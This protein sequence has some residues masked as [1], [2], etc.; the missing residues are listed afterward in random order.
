MAQRKTTALARPKPPTRR[1]SPPTPSPQA[2]KACEAVIQARQSADRAQLRAS[3]Q[4]VA[5]DLPAAD[6]DLS[7]PW[8]IFYALSPLTHRGFETLMGLAP[9]GAPPPHWPT[10][11]ER[12]SAMARAAHPLDAPHRLKPIGALSDRAGWG[13]ALEGRVGACEF[14]WQPKFSRLRKNKAKTSWMPTTRW[15]RDDENGRDLFDPRR[16]KRRQG[17]DLP[18]AWERRFGA[19]AARLLWELGA[20]SSALAK[21]D[22]L[23]PASSPLRALIEALREAGADNVLWLEGFSQAF[24]AAGK[25]GGASF[26]QTLEQ[27]TLDPVRAAWIL[28]S[29]SNNPSNASLR[30]APT[31]L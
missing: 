22:P 8:W 2:L 29:E 21:P 7:R 6:L 30:P 16:A 28:R 14:H 10:L 17:R 4:D 20:S 15:I 25:P 1:A 18:A 19:H 3:A 11:F 31:A 13:V 23:C 5:S 12:A 9:K 26:L 27:Q 24:P